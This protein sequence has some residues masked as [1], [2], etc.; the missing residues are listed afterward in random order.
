MPTVLEAADSIMSQPIIL[1]PGDT[2]RMHKIQ[3][4]SLQWILELCAQAPPPPHNSTP[5]ACPREEQNYHIFI[6]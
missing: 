3:P 4:L 1:P 5:V 2:V 6:M